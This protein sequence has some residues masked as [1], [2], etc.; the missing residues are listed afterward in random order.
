MPI[1]LW[2]TFYGEYHA[3]QLNNGI[4]PEYMQIFIQNDELKKA[5]GKANLD[6]KI[7]KKVRDGWP[8]TCRED[9][10][11]YSRGFNKSPEEFFRLKLVAYP[12]RI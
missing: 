6:S 2:V 10:Q 7:L 12:V 1:K 5:Q 4:A 3:S 11:N 8:K 9:I